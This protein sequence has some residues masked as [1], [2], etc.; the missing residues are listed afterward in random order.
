[1]VLSAIASDRSPPLPPLPPLPPSG[2]P[3]TLVPA[4]L[5]RAFE[6]NAAVPAPLK[7]AHGAVLFIVQ[8]P[9]PP[10]PTPKGWLD[11]SMRQDSVAGVGGFFL[12]MVGLF[13]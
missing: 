8:A 3:G 7:A 9:R 5:W 13:H 12:K 11:Q 10:P 6:L 2:A 4:A 1:M